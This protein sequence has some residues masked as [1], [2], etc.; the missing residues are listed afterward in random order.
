MIAASSD[1]TDDSV[2]VMIACTLTLANRSRRIAAQL[3]SVSMCSSAANFVNSTSSVAS[4]FGA[5]AIS[6]SLSDSSRSTDR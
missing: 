2:A 3:A 5:T 6:R 1:D 4:Y